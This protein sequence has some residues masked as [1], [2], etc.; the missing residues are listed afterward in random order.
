VVTEES[1]TRDDLL[2]GAVAGFNNP[3]LQ[4]VKI[5]DS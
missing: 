5:L 1:L 4:S 2:N 3:S